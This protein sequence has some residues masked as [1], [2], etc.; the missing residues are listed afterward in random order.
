MN[1]DFFKEFKFKIN[2]I[3]DIN[4]I[5]NGGGRAARRGGGLHRH[6]ASV[7][8]EDCEEEAAAIDDNGEE[9][10]D[11]DTELG[12]IVF[13]ALCRR[14]QVVRRSPMRV[15]ECQPRRA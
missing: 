8:A 7:W 1:F 3:N 15:A 14:C 13:C 5:I 12:R 11:D 10:G 9:D 6:V 4:D 2:Y